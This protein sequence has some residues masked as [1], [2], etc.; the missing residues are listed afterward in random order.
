L[1]ENNYEELSSTL[2][3]LYCL[4]YHV[5]SSIVT[6]AVNHL[7]GHRVKSS[8]RIDVPFVPKLN[9][10]MKTAEKLLA[11]F[12]DPIPLDAFTV[13]CTDNSLNLTPAHYR[14]LGH[15]NAFG[16]MNA[17]PRIKPTKVERK[18]VANW[19][20]TVFNSIPIG[21]TPRYFSIYH[22]SIF[23]NYTETLYSLL[24][25]EEGW[26]ALIGSG[27]AGELK[28]KRINEYFRQQGLWD[29]WLRVVEKAEKH[30]KQSS[31]LHLNLIRSKMWVYF[32]TR[33]FEEAKVLLQNAPDI[34][35]KGGDSSYKSK[36]KYMKPHMLKELIEKYECDGV[37]DYFAISLLGRAYARLWLKDNSKTNTLLEKAESYIKHALDESTKK[38]DLIEASVQSWYLAC[39]KIDLNKIEEA[40]ALLADVKRLDESIMDRK[41]G[42]AWLKVANYRLMMKI[43]DDE[44]FISNS[45]LEAVNAMKSLG[46]QNVE[47]FVDKE[48]YY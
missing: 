3:S 30:V 1:E 31:S 27:K 5:D 22:K 39:I 8:T 10:D 34:D 38:K 36:L 19:L 12:K 35:T 32:W 41:P 42:I 6:P 23:D 15:T 4:T 11:V 9:K 37:Q 14:L 28:F 24:L 2:L 25:T 48:Y 26:E 40:K 29:Q 13:I 7:L 33:R 20:A 16:A 21:K 47:D 46:M 43:S 17:N 44:A 18:I 45:R